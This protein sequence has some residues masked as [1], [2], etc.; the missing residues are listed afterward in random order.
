MTLVIDKL[1]V[2]DVSLLAVGDIKSSLMACCNDDFGCVGNILAI[3]LC[4]R[5][6]KGTYATA[7]FQMES[8]IGLSR[9][10][11]ICHLITNNN[12]FENFVSVIEQTLTSA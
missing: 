6:R 4:Y 7:C 8:D 1:K 2:D 11:R 10:K 12:I 3:C 9:V 5:F